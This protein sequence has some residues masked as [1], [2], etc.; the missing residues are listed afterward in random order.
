VTWH[1]LP[2]SLAAQRNEM[3]MTLPGRVQKALGSSGVTART[4][5]FN[6]AECAEGLNDRL[7]AIRAGFVFS[8]FL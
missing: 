4:Q 7:A 2:T 8:P 6:A 1:E 5:V 3:D